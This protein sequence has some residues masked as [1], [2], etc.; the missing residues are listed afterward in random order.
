MEII[1]I[2]YLYVYDCN[3]SYIPENRNK[4]LYNKHIWDFSDVVR[5]LLE[6]VRHWYLWNAHV[7]IHTCGPNSAVKNDFQII[8]WDSLDVVWTLLDKTY[9]SKY[10]SKHAYT[11]V[12]YNITSKL[13]SLGYARNRYSLQKQKN[14]YKM[15]KFFLHLVYDLQFMFGIFRTFSSERSGNLSSI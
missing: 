6:F 15:H 2:F 11:S 14:S 13:F 1:S 12:S 10:I 9:S 4:C 5:T 3:I 8:I 7:Y